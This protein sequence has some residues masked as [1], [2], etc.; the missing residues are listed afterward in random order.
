MS[1]RMSKQRVFLLGGDAEHA[2]TLALPPLFSPEGS[3]N[4]HVTKQGELEAMAGY[5]N[6]NTATTTDTGGSAAR[7]TSG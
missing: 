7:V 5:T 2:T 6:L 3:Q 1:T 4:M